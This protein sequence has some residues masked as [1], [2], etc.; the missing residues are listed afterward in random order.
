MFGLRDRRTG[1][2]GRFREVWGVLRS[3]GE[4]W[5]RHHHLPI[6]DGWG[7]V[8]RRNDFPAFIA[9]SVVPYNPL[10]LSD[11]V[12]KRGSLKTAYFLVG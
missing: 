2:L 9:T 8:Q 4:F 11:S 5:S 3:F 12:T 6:Y 7:F 10:I 1:V